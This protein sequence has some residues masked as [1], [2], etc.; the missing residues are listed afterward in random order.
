MD[1]TAVRKEDNM[2]K[3]ML[4]LNEKFEELKKH[5]ICKG[6]SCAECEHRYHD[7]DCD[8]N[9]QKL[10]VDKCKEIVQEVAK[11][12]D[13]IPVTERLPEPFQRVLVYDAWDDSITIEYL[14]E[15]DSFIPAVVAWVPLPTAP[16][17]KGE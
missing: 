14:K 2:K 4:C 12:Y 8:K 15:N 10:V 7:R 1:G 17:Q 13:W 6:M 3:F 9:V 11:E 16:Y 5:D